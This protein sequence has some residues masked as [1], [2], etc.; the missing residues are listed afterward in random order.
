MIHHI[1]INPVHR[2]NVIDVNVLIKSLEKD[3]CKV[4]YVP[5]VLFNSGFRSMDNRRMYTLLYAAYPQLPRTLSIDKFIEFD[6]LIEWME[7][8]NSSNN[9]HVINQEWEHQMFS[10][11]SL[12]N[13]SQYLPMSLGKLINQKTIS[14]KSW[15]KTERK[16]KK[17][18]RNVTKRLI[19]FR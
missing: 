9:L 2:Q 13:I 6:I 17:M 18:K 15:I 10:L 12:M 4:V 14:Y 5:F 16:T 11:H 1:P 19:N 3:A 7:L 8:F